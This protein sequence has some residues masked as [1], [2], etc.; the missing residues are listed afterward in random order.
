MSG[1]L[2]L[3]NDNFSVNSGTKGK[4]LCNNI[5]GYSLVLFYSTECVHCQNLIPIFKKLP[6]TIN[7]CSFGMVNISQNM[8]IIEKSKQTISPITYVPYILMFID[9][10][11]YMKYNG[12]SQIEEIKRFIVEVVSAVNKQKFAVNT[13]KKSQQSNAPV[14]DKSNIPSYTT[15]IPVCAG[16]VCYIQFDKG[17]K[18][19]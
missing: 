13:E 18:Q 19:K 9:G 7:N 16:D 3:T 2:F 10:V 8:G 4:I 1:L 5:K 6:N 11:P 17:Y 14:L 12:P 15:G